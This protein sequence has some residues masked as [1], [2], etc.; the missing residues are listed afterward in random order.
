MPK[1]P[2]NVQK[3]DIRK[4]PKSLSRLVPKRFTKLFIKQRTLKGKFWSGKFSAT[5]TEIVVQSEER[6]DD[7]K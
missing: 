1:L 7:W 5:E 2:Q 6:D 4:I 3:L